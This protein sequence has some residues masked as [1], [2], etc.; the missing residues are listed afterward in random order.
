MKITNRNAREDVSGKHND[1]NFNVDYAEHIDQ[2][3]SHENI[4]WTH[5]GDTIS[6]F[7]E[8]ERAFY[9]Q[10]FSDKLEEQNQ[11][12]KEARN[13]SRIKTMLK[14]YHDKRTRPEDK[15][16]Q[17]GNA[18]EHATKEE[19]W[20]CALEYRDRFEELYGDHCVIL[21]MALHMDEATPHVHI[22]RV[23][24]AED[25]N[26]WEYVSESKA[27][28]QLGVPRPQPDKPESKYNNAKIMLT[29]NE[30]ELFRQICIDRGLDIDKPT[31][32]DIKKEHLPVLE[33]K[34]EVTI[35]Q[36]EEL[37]AQLDEMKED[38]FRFLQENPFLINLYAEELMEAERK[39][40]YE[41]NKR[42]AE[43]VAKEY[44]RIKECGF[45]GAY[46]QAMEESFAKYLN[47]RDMLEDYDTW[48]DEHQIDIKMN[49][50]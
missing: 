33:Y 6:T 10:H 48:K 32:S 49:D 39:S 2:S 47:S 3:R 14:Y 5:T 45:E 15:I 20:D 37:E 26:G 38:M 4:Y 31:K 17:I 42:I 1:R 40:K 30:V 50:R 29:Q 25:E 34:K 27:L 16:L 44:N 22:R 13:Y 7:E 8:I 35:K 19:L 21:D 28:E 36:I 18:K 46:A 41:R 12:H 11:K 24:I 23:W 9:E 43:I